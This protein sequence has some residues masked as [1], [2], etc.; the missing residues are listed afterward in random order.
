MIVGH[1]LHIPR[2]RK[3]KQHIVAWLDERALSPGKVRQGE[4]DWMY[5]GNNFSYTICQAHV[6]DGYGE[7]ILTFLISIYDEPTQVEFKLAFS[8]VLL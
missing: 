3:L 1:P 7:A 5:E 8:E 2:D 4:P 6:R